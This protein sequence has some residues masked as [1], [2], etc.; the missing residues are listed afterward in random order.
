MKAFTFISAI[1]S[2]LTLVS[3]HGRLRT[4]KPLGYGTTP[5]LDGNA[6]NAPLKHD[7]SD[8]PCKGLIGKVD[9]TPQAT[10]KAGGKGMFEIWPNEG[11]GG[12]GN[13]AAHSGGSCQLSLSFDNGKTFKVIHTWE[14]G[15]PRDVPLGSN[16]AGNNQTFTADIPANTRAGKAIAAW[17]WIARTGNRGEYYMNCASVKIEGSGTSTLNDLPDMWVGDLVTGGITSSM[18][19]STQQYFFVYP[20]PGKSIT[21]TTESGDFKGPTGAGPDGSFNICRSPGSGTTPPP[22]PTIVNPPP[23]TPPPKPSGTVPPPPFQTFDAKVGGYIY[24]CVL[25]A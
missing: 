5:Q 7:G 19:L 1:L 10:W 15:C 13:M 8:F 25:K 16:I 6:Y 9:M 3:G 23:V 11:N 18:C 21:K 22:V 4:P 2:T 12:E 24:Q 14:G 20:N 17:S